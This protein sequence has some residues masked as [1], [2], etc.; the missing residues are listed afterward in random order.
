[1]DTAADMQLIHTLFTFQGQKIP[2]QLG[3]AELQLFTK[4]YSINL[5]HLFVVSSISS[6]KLAV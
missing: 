1:M 3:A 5:F 2:Q 6:Q 4:L